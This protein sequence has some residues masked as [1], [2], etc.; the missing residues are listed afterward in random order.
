MYY[1]YGIAEAMT[2]SSVVKAKS[3]GELFQKYPVLKSIR[4]KLDIV[5]NKIIGFVACDG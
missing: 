2:G 1:L 4:Q 5:G 3:L